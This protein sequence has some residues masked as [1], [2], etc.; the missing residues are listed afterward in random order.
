MLK[1]QQLYRR[2][3]RRRRHHRR[4]RRR[5][6]SSLIMPK[7]PRPFI[8]KLEPGQ[9]TI[10]KR[11]RDADPRQEQPEQQQQLQRRRTN[12]PEA[13]TAV[14]AA[15]VVSL[16]SGQSS[17]A[18]AQLQKALLLGHLPS[19]AALAWML[20]FG[21]QGVAKDRSRAFELAE[22]GA[23]LGCHDCQGIQPHTQ[24]PAFFTA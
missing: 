14:A 10:P 17:L 6:S 22:E 16:A 4:H 7:N 24:P 2:G 9:D 21:R 23:R 18:A 20:A 13:V 8:I 11:E 12:G 15:A 19:R 1:R 3:H 5:S